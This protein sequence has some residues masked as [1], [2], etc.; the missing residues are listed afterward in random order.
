MPDPASRVLLVDAG[1]NLDVFDV[2]EVNGATLRVRT[3]YLFELVEEMKVRIEQDG[4]T[5]EATARVLAHVDAEASG[6]DKV[7]ELELT[8]RTAVT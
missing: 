2:V 8:E 1:K 5:F 6:D 3:G 7:T 4:T